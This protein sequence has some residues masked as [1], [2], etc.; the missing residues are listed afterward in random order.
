LNKLPQSMIQKGDY[1][2]HGSTQATPK[3]IPNHTIPFHLIKRE[4]QTACNR[5][6][7]YHDNC[8]LCKGSAMYPRIVI[9][10]PVGD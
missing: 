8:T 5:K 9:S 10:S 4:S 7:G 6:L 3:I 1:G 2:S